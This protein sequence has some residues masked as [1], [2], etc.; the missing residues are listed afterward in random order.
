MYEVRMSQPQ[1]RLR[2]ESQLLSAACRVAVR[3]GIQGLT[4]EEVGRLAGYSRGQ[5]YQ[6]FGSREGL[7]IAS[8]HYLETRRKNLVAGLQLDGLDGMHALLNHFAAHLEVATADIEMA[9]F[10]DILTAH[11]PN[12]P[13]MRKAVGIAKS[14]LLDET[15]GLIA[16]GLADGSIHPSVSCS[17]DAVLYL[18]LMLGVANEC[19]E[20]GPDDDLRSLRGRGREM[21]LRSFSCSKSSKPCSV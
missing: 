14:D 19:T 4:C 6:R 13:E 21:V 12:L 2:S 17:E 7:L 3:V 8:V 11:I 20:A 18:H 1:R 9:A 15:G 10:F 5:T 16:K